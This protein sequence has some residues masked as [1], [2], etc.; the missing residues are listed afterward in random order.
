M[1]GEIGLLCRA[2]SVL[3]VPQEEIDNF[4]QMK[5]EDDESL[6]GNFS[7]ALVA[8]SPWAVEVESWDPI[9]ILSDLADVLEG[10]GVAVEVDEK[11][12]QIEVFFPSDGKR[13][14]YERP[15][16]QG[17]FYYKP[18]VEDE[19]IHEVIFALELLLP[20][21]VEIYSLAYLDSTSSPGFVVLGSEQRD[22][23]QNVLGNG[24][25]CLFAKHRAG[26][27]FCKATEGLG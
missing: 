2:L 13:L 15:N 26:T 19:C 20:K 1:R 17:D 18:L 23:L 24:F 8:N 4:A 25:A 5:H 21:E 12:G 14:P 6:M 11:D 27:V 7:E 9:E 16:R 3:G 10:L 22:E